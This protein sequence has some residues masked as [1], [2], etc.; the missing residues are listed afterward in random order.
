MDKM[1][2]SMKRTELDIIINE[3]L[4]SELNAKE[5]IEKLNDDLFSNENLFKMYD[6]LKNNRQ[7]SVLEHFY[8]EQLN[9]I[10]IHPNEIKLKEMN[11]LEV[12]E[13]LE[14]LREDAFYTRIQELK[15]LEVETLPMYMRMF[16]VDE[17]NVSIQN[18]EK[19]HIENQIDSVSNELDGFNYY[20]ANSDYEL[21]ALFDFLKKEK[22][23][24]KVDKRM[25]KVFFREKFDRDSPKIQ[26][27]GSVSL[28]AMMIKKMMRMKKDK[29]QIFQKKGASYHHILDNVFE[30]LKSRNGYK[31]P[32]EIM[33]TNHKSK[34][35]VQLFEKFLIFLNA[36][37]KPDENLK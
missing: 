33:N 32:S 26:F 19:E 25:F 22:L 29:K 18:K 12:L 6:Y 35:D 28:F 17:F 3:F 20:K 21:D 37:F 27:I 10:P 2:N 8:E 1:E 9:S 14:I 31:K 34:K 7:E 15:K 11:H 23:I 4:L 30:C 16:Q 13:Y 24:D 5:F 36:N